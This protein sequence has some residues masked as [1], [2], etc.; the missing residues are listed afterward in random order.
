MLEYTVAWVQNEKSRREDVVYH[1][2]HDSAGS[3][4]LTAASSPSIWNIYL[5]QISPTSYENSLFLYYPVVVCT[6]VP[7]FFLF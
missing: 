2:L 7:I 1:D 5:F 4:R 3:L 6:V